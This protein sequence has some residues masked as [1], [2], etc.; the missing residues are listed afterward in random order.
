LIAAIS[1]QVSLVAV[2]ANLLAA[3]AVGPATVLGLLGGLLTLVAPP[4]G[5]L[6]GAGAGW[7]VAWIVEVARQMASL[8]TPAVGWGSS[9]VAIALLVA[10]SAVLAVLGPRLVR[11]RTTGLACCGVLVATVL[12]RV[13]T[14]GWP[15]DGWLLVACDVGQGDGLV[16]NTGV[17]HTAVVV[18]AGPDPK[19][20]DACLSGLGVSRI[21]LVVLTH[22]H[23]DHVDGLP[24]VLGG[25]DV[26]EVDVSRLA[27]PPAGVALV[28]DAARAA[29][30][31][32]R[33]APYAVTRR[34]GDVSLEPV[35]PLPGAPTVGPGDG[36][37]ANNASVVLL[38][39]IRG[40][41]FFLGGDIE[42]EGQATLAAML[43]GL[44]VDVLKVPHHGSRYQD[45][46]FLE[47][48]GARLDLISVGADN[49]YGHPAAETVAALEST[50]AQVL[51]TD[52]GGSIAVVEDGGRLTA[53]TRSR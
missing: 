31:A 3:P 29:G 1:G 21:P 26:A 42:P 33:E 53:V 16:L 46:A 13:P 7:C 49:D 45:L 37:T 43:P 11:R 23:A 38:A 17:R 35:W 47:S 41:R 9:P 5:R 32:P 51:R 18:D 10:V 28:R 50:G 39:R 44:H 30:L 22:F 24:G 14:P 8:P 34:I 2:L 20:M 6:V 52:R 48:L 25:R 27:D 19:A 4:L 40:V 12:V 15:P 36:S